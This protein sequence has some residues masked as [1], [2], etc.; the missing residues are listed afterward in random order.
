MRSGTQAL[1]GFPNPEDDHEWRFDHVAYRMHISKKDGQSWS[2]DRFTNNWNEQNHCLFEAG[3]LQRF[4]KP[5]DFALKQGLA[6]LDPDF[7]SISNLIS[8][9]PIA[10][11]T[12]QNKFIWTDHILHLMRD[13][14]SKP[15]VF[16]I[17]NGNRRREVAKSVLASV[18]FSFCLPRLNKLCAE[19]ILEVKRSRKTI[20]R[21]FLLIF[22]DCQVD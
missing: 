22:K 4:G 18:I 17:K 11:T 21:V 1:S 9:I 20:V 2:V 12:F 3:I 16:L 13:D 5:E 19:E 8:D 7:K 15:G 10:F 14:L 6:N